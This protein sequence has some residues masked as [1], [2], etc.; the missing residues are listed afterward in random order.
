[1]RL[2]ILILCRSSVTFN[3][4]YANTTSANHTL[5]IT[6]SNTSSAKTSIT[7]QSSSA[8][9][10][11]TITVPASSKTVSTTVSLA[12]GS[13]NTIVI[14]SNLPIDSIQVQSPTGTYYPSTAFTLSGSATHTQCGSGFCQP[15][16][17]KIGY[18]DSTN[19][20]KITVPATVP[21]NTTSAK[22]LEL[23]YINNDVAFSSTWGLGANSRNITISLNGGAPVRLE[24][25]LS[26]RHS[27]LFGP[28]LGWWDTASLGLLVNGW[29]DGDNEVVVSNAVTGGFQSWGADFVGF[30]VFD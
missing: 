4:I 26:G 21:A 6:F 10:K 23:D 3:S 5:L 28:G 12:A 30:R 24:V 17:S 19:A 7:V 11:S 9:Q 14:T 25:P 15:V 1:M 8:Q 13:A 18:L 20:A 16:G 29:K 27:E 22:Y 2:I